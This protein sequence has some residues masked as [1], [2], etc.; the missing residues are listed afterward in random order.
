MALSPIEV[1]A[2]GAYAYLRQQALGKLGQIGG[3]VGRVIGDAPFAALTDGAAQTAAD[4]NARTLSF[5][6]KQYSPQLKMAAIG[7][8][9]V[10]GLGTL[11]LL[12]LRRKK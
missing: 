3:D 1:K 10:V 8:L 12:V 11:L 9:V 5:V 7:L 2:A 4:E 6:I